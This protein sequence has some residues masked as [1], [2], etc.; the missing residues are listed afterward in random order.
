M[1][2]SVWA[3][4]SLALPTLPLKH[5]NSQREI[6]D[7]VRL[8]QEN[9]IESRRNLHFM[10]LFFFHC[11]QVY[12]NGGRALNSQAIQKQAA[13]GYELRGHCLLFLGLVHGTLCPHCLLSTIYVLALHLPEY[14]RKKLQAFSGLAPTYSI[15]QG[16]SEPY[17]SLTTR[18]IGGLCCLCIQFS[19]KQED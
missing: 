8:F 7:G 14:T 16:C 3:I 5:K 19:P 2:S 10:Q 15:L 4:Q 9:F 13:G 17:L 18:Q 6:S 11:S 1:F 12:R